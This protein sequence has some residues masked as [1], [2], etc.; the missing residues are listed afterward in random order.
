MKMTR[1][2]F[3]LIENYMKECM[4]DSAHDKEH[5][6]RVLYTALEI[7]GTEEGVD[8]D[9]L[10]TSC[11][12]HDIGRGEQFENPKLCHA[13]VGADKAFVFLKDRGFETGFCEKV[14]HCIAAHRYRREN[15]PESI[16][17][18]ILFDADKTDVVGAVGIARTLLYKGNVGEPLYTV[19]DGI[20]S[21]GAGDTEPS[22]MQEYKYKL[23]GIYSRF[24]TAKGAEIAKSRQA[25]AVGFY[26]ALYGEVSKAYIDG[27]AKLNKILEE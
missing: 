6:Y 27:T 19:T 12:L 26:E 17:A 15:E 13:L 22:F 18:K 20:V 11:L 14:R 24:Y 16:E 21:D 3:L 7:A 1:E 4:R 10:I 2:T 25:V 9:V 23:E 8:Y 5:I